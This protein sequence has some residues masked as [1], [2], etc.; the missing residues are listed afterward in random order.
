MKI[1]NINYDQTPRTSGTMFV[2]LFVPFYPTCDTRV[3]LVGNDEEFGEW[4]YKN[5][6]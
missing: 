1:N 2:S 3:Y 4:D 5:G 6:I